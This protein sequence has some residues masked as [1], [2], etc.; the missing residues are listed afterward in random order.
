MDGLVWLQV[1]TH[2]NPRDSREAERGVT[3][4]PQA[5][6]CKDV[7]DL[8]DIKVA[9]YA[10]PPLIQFKIKA[11]KTDPFRQ[12]L[13]LHISNTGSRLCQG[14]AVL[15]YTVARS[16][17]PGSQEGTPRKAWMSQSSSSLESSSDDSRVPSVP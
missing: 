16:E 5:K 17:V 11:S 2:N 1:E 14:M 15:S 7:V 13:T 4:K 9:T 3:Q 10:R 12:G 6:G 8:E